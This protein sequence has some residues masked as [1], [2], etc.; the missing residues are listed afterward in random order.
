MLT[1]DAKGMIVRDSMIEFA[2]RTGLSPEGSAPERYLWTDAFAVCNF[3]GLY[4]QTGD[5]QYRRLALL[6]VDQVHALLGRHRPDDRRTGWISGLDEEEGK[7]HPTRGGLRI[8]KKMRER[9]PDEPFDQDL[10][11]DR[12]G[13]Y[14]HYLTQ[15]MHTLDCVSRATGDLIFNSWAMELAKAAHAGFSYAPGKG[16]EK[17]LYWKMSIDLSRPLVSSMGH[18]DPLDGLIAYSE[19]QATA[20]KLSER[21]TSRELGAEIADMAALCTGKDW[22]TDDPLGIGGLL[23]NAFRM[24]QLI[25]A[26]SFI[27]RDLFE[28]VLEDCLR[29]LDFFESRSPLA[30]PAAYRLAFREFGLSIGLQAI[31]KLQG[32]IDQHPEVFRKLSGRVRMQG[33]GRYVPMSEAINAFWLEGKNRQSAAWAEHL[34]INMMMLVTSLSPDGYLLPQ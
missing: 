20:G 14:F 12:D 21:S 29:S 1:P 26:G 33:F 28:T 30:L 9:R 15:W 24:A 31:Q 7:R 3:L 27:R 22:A 10:E 34:A 2:E 18:H 17:R 6:L 5:E 25:L 16:V 8:G 23:I 32:L 4:R 19:I 11:W 13:Q